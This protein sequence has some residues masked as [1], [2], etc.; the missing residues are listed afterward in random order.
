MA[1]I[2]SFNR[3][4]SAF[5]HTLEECNINLFCENLGQI[6]PVVQEKTPKNTLQYLRGENEVLLM[7]CHENEGIAL[8]PCAFG[9]LQ[10]G[11]D[12][13]NFYLKVI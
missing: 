9:T 6:I 10:R 1:P 13:R 7:L 2:Y 3:R 11:H 8:V 4:R 5:K 12:V